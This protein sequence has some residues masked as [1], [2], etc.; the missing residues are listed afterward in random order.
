MPLQRRVPKRGFRPFDRVEYAIVN[1]GQLAAFAPGS[2]VDPD[3]LRAKRLVR[4]HG[5]VKCLGR[6]T[7]PHALSV[8]AHAFSAA[9]RDAITAAGG[10]AE[11]LRA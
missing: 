1:L 6:G 5:P 8:R 2:I 11:V 9:A 10:T 4:G 7:L 3:A